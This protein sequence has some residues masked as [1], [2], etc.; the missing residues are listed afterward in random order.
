MWD[1][2]G[3]WAERLREKLYSKTMES[4]GAEYT[5]VYNLGIRGDS[6][7][8]VLDR[9]RTELE[10]RNRHGEHELVVIIQA[11]ANDAQFVYEEDDVATPEDEF[12][13]TVSKLAEEAEK[14]AEEVVFLGLLPVDEQNFDPVPN[15]IEGRSFSN[16]R[17]ESYS[18]IIEEE[19]EETGCHFLN[20]MKGFDEKLLT[21]GV[22]P[23]TEGHE[24]LYTKIRAFLQKEDIV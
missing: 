15:V 22:H 24:H 17:M 23:G 16:N 10:N 11:G 7:K 2:E 12:R 20:I 9:F 18:E 21:D 14:R 8:E 5:E 4:K 19:V 1:S 13:E 6:M 3:G